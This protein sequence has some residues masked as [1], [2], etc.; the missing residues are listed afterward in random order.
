MTIPSN[1]ILIVDDTEINIDILLD[2]LSDQYDITVATDGLSALEIVEQ[3]VISLIL[4]DITMPDMD[5]YEVCRRL[6]NHR[7]TES[8]PIIFITA[9]TDEKSIEKA[10]NVGGIDYIT[11]PFKPKE[12]LARIKTQ[13][14]MLALIDSLKFLASYD[15]MT[16][17][18][19]RRRFFELVEQMFDNCSTLYAI[20]IDIDKFKAINDAFGHPVG[21]VIIKTVVNVIKGYVKADS[22]F[23]RLG[24]EEFAIICQSETI[25]TVMVDIEIIRKAVAA[26]SI[27]VEGKF[28]CPT[29]S[30]GITQK[31]LSTTTIDLLL[32]KADD[33]LYEAKGTGRNRSVFRV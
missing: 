16:G 21:D 19:N 25:E 10:Y 33:A 32:K 30:C 14:E 9:N 24:G 20:M 11:K 22:I 5:G 8:I 6:K 29:I 15:E 12:V 18:Y 27:E 26:Q 23:A 1:T 4:L 28:I 31:D 13:F 7:K 3:E 2:I 17:I